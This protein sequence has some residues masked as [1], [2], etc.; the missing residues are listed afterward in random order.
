M[1]LKSFL[2]GAA[3]G[4]TTAIIAK[5]LLDST[6][7]YS[8]DK[9]LINIKEQVKENGSIYGSWIMMNPE[10]YEKNNVNYEV[11]R[12]GVTRNLNGK[13]EQFEFIVNAQTGA[14]LELN[15]LQKENETL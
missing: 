7:Y 5:E 6:K 10:M 12:G 3:T 11:Y 13:Q 4:F 8:P 15:L 2:I 14:V 9:V 1:N